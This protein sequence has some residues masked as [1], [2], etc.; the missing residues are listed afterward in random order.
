MAKQWKRLTIWTA[1]GVC[2]CLVIAGCNMEPADEALATPTKTMQT[3]LEASKALRRA[4]TVPELYFKTLKAFCKAERQWFDGQ[5]S[6]LEMPEAAKVYQPL[7]LDS[8]N[9]RAALFAF[10][11]VAHGPYG[12]GVTEKTVSDTEATVEV[13]GYGKPVMLVKEGPNWRIK[14]LFGIRK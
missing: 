13:K 11:V 4:P 14:E 5:F 12:G 2:L 8:L 1:V 10:C 9:K 6:T 7:I 3:Y